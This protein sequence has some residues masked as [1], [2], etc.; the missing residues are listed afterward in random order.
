MSHPPPYVGAEPAR[1]AGPFFTPRDLGTASFYL[2]MEC[3]LETAIAM[4]TS[5]TLI[6]PARLVAS[7]TAL[8]DRLREAADR[9]REREAR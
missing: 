2:G 5:T 1:P 4:V 8:R 6:D 3:G 7:M 9:A